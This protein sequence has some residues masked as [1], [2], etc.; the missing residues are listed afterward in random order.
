MREDVPE[1]MGKNSLRQTAV[2]VRADELA[3]DESDVIGLGGIRRYPPDEIAFKNRRRWYALLTMINSPHHFPT[4]GRSP[5]LP[6]ERMQVSTTQASS[7]PL[8]FLSK[9][10]SPVL[11]RKTPTIAFPA[12]SQSPVT[13]R[14]YI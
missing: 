13:G 10:H 2:A 7:C 3:V 4:T 1:P 5:V 11:G 12:P 9:N 14:S 6:K 8:P